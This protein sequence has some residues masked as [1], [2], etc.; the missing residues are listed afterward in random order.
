M[1]V[2]VAGGSLV[3]VEAACAAADQGA[4]VLVVESRPYLGYDL[5]ANQK[6]WLDPDEQPQTEITQ[7]LFQDSRKVTPLGEVAAGSRA[8]KAEY[9]VSDRQLSRRTVGG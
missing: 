5:C 4:S 7:Q 1:D 6:L 3:G 9:Q 8:V 2:V